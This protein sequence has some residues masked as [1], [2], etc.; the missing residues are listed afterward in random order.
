[1]S[2]A[3]APRARYATG[4]ARAVWSDEPVLTELRRLLPIQRVA[5]EV[6][7]DRSVFCL[8]TRQIAEA[9]RSAF[10]SRQVF[11]LSAREWEID[12]AFAREPNQR[13]GVNF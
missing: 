1:M 10:N 6:V 2:H 3:S 11:V 12:T 8:R 9:I 4:S 13:R 5:R 7:S